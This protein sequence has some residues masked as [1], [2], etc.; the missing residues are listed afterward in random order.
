MNQ[1]QRIIFLFFYNFNKKKKNEKFNIYK[2]I[3]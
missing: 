2:F 3:Y 1:I